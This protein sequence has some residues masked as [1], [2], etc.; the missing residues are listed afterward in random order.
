M[1]TVAVLHRPVTR[2][3]HLMFALLLLFALLW[4]TDRAFPP[5]LPAGDDGFIVLARDGSPLRAWPG[6][7]GAWRYPVSPGE[8]SPRY[9]EALLGYEDRWF[10]L[11]PGVNPASLVRAAW[12]WA[13]Q[14]RVVSGGSTLTMQVARILEPVPRTPLGKLRQIA[15]A[16]Q[17]EWHLS[18]DDILTLYLNHAPMGGIVEGVE[19]ASRIYL[20]KPSR[21]LS[22][23]EAALLAT[24]P[25][26]P[27]R[28]RPDRS[29]HAAQAARDRVLTRLESFGIWTRDVVTDARIEPVIAQR[30]QG[31]W[32]APLAAERLRG[33]TKRSQ[34]HGVM[35]VAS[36]LDREL[37]ATVERLL[38][39]RASVLPPKVSI[40]ALVMEVD[41]LEVRAYAGSA[42]FTDAGRS[43][44]VDMVRGVRSPGS[45]LK[46]FLYAMALDDGLIHS[47]SLLIDAPQTFGGYQ[48]GNFQADFSGPVS[49]A[50]ALQRSL[51]V[52]AVDLLDQLT[53]QRF[54]SQLAAG[55]LKLRIATAEQAN[56]SLIL[57]GA[58]VT[59]EELVGGYRALAAGGLA[60][61]PRLVPDAPLEES[62]LMSEGAAWIVRDILEGGGHP[63]R[64][65]VEGT[66]AAPLAWKTGTSFGFRDAWA[67]GVAGRH[68][69]GVWIGRPDGTPNPGFFGANVAAPLLK[70]IAAALPHEA[71][72]A[73][74]RPASVRRVDICWPLGVAVADTPAALCHRRRSAWSLAGAVP[75]TRPDRIDGSSLRQTIRINPVTG[76]RTVSGCGNGQRDEARRDIAR[77]PVLLQ[78]WLAGWLPAA[79][80]LPDWQPGCTPSGAATTATLRIVGLTEGTRLRPAPRQRHVTLQLQVRGAQ[81]TVYWLL[82]GRRMQ[83]GAGG[84]LLLDEPGEHRLTAMDGEGRHH[85]VRFTLDPAPGARGV[86]AQ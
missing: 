83:P 4:L 79:Q 61:K 42:D 24:L 38:A 50:E 64:P 52:P 19:M 16:L 13:T 30:V 69:L 85:S 25:R 84:T 70:D 57:G 21:D 74:T 76:L 77:W 67:V 55:G 62:R 8:V 26:A 49:A 3:R 81:G 36:T 39:D 59:L 47:E 58:G 73:Q 72:P 20:G 29:P 15:R 10:R 51:N 37:Q 17:L 2:H 32:L 34:Q 43:A 46:P 75:P 71:P 68:A 18:K 22:H 12:Q 45:T 1:R 27:S 78:P 9:V 23:A 31:V 35:R 65:F 11:H 41:T 44:H 5:P 33:Q 82:D 80:H 28:L 7:N 56:L 6:A 48:P 54:A 14:R 53:P 60:G 86:P 63:D 40:A 66:A